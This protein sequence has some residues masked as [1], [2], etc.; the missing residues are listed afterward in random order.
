MPNKYY[1]FFNLLATPVRMEIISL[2]KERGTMSVGEIC[3]AIHEEQSKISH[4]LGKLLM[5]KVVNV[6]QEKNFRYY[7]LNEETMIPM[8]K[9]IDQHASSCCGV[10]KRLT[11]RKCN[12]N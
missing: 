6:R 12:A 9:L 7:S 8:L 5:C 3:L 4:N 2:L 11:D 10:C 1:L